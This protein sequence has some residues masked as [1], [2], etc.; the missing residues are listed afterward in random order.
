MTTAWTAQQLVET[1]GMDEKLKYLLRDRDA[2][3]GKQSWVGRLPFMDRLRQHHTHHHNERLMTRYNFNIIYPN[4]DYLCD[5]DY[6][7]E[8]QLIGARA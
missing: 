8:Q 6:A 7:N 2:I 5:T 1:C 3:Y 4:F